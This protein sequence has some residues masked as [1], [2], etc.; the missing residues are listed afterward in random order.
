M[1]R[2]RNGGGHAS[3]LF[4]APDNSL[5]QR[6]SLVVN[7]GW[8]IFMKEM[9]S[10]CEVFL[11]LAETNVITGN[12]WVLWVSTSIKLFSGVA[13][14]MKNSVVEFCQPQEG[15]DPHEVPPK[16]FK[17]TLYIASTEAL[18]VEKRRRCF[19]KGWEMMK[20]V[21][22]EPRQENQV[23][24]D[25]VLASST[26][27]HSRI[28]QNTRKSKQ[29]SGYLVGWFNVTVKRVVMEKYL[30]EFTLDKKKYY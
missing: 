8:I 30:C 21:Y 6:A 25:A 4:G 24:S 19:Q 11:M 26:K 18:A 29:R 27:N 2:R 1:K 3:N 28:E 22:H 10:S 9:T 7:R 15:A 12:R 16:A 5:Y 13:L 20:L 17:N 14:K 23:G